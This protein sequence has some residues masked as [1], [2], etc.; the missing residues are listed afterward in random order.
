MA[1]L[2]TELVNRAYYLAGIV[3][4]DMETVSGS[5]LNDGI[6][7][8]NDLLALKS[9]NS[10]LVPYFRSYELVA[11]IGQETYFVPNLIY[12]D[13]VTF[14]L[15]GTVRVPLKIDSRKEYFG[16]VRVNDIVTLPFECNINRVEGGADFY[17]YP[18][19]NDNYPIAIWGKFGLSS[20][21]TYD[22]DL[23]LWYDRFYIAYLRYALA[24]FI[25]AENS[26]DFPP[27]AAEK[28]DMLE[29][30]VLD[31]SPIDT[32]VEKLSTLRRCGQGG[33]WGFVNLGHGWTAP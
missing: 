3:A 32:T 13:S 14:I 25:C 23:S 21:V 10:R 29:Q 24:E 6:S 2:A 12:P 5:Q 33:G 15:N 18:L 7:L 26:L 20:N 4:R 8:L 11:T 31:V 27:Q 30:T 19:P 9:A 16:S 17:I 22:T 1:Y 28:L